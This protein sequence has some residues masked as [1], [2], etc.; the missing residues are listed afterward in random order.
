M[1]ATLLLLAVS[2]AAPDAPRDALRLALMHG[3]PDKWNV[4][5][6]FAA[7]LGQRRGHRPKADVFITPECWLDGYA[8]PDKASTPEKLRTVAQDLNR[9]RIS[10]ASR[11]EAKRHDDMFRVHVARNDRLYNG[12]AVG[13]GRQPHRAVPQDITDMTYSSVGKSCRCGTR[14][15]AKSA[16]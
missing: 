12:G 15:L 8:A 2:A 11:K 6:N 9:A 10:N 3:V 13:R 5:G 7:F 14:R 4:Q 16:L 1:L